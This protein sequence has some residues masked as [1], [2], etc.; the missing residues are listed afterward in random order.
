LDQVPIRVPGTLASQPKDVIGPLL[1]SRQEDGSEIRRRALFT[2]ILP[3]VP[4]Q[5]LARFVVS[6]LTADALLGLLSTTTL[7]KTGYVNV[8]QLQAETSLEE[9]AAKC[10]VSLDVHGDGK[11]V[12]LDCPFGCAGD[13]CGRREIAVNTDNPQKV[14]MCH[15]YQ[16]GFRG[17]LLTLMHGWL[18][19][20]RPADDKLRGDEFHRVKSIVASAVA[21]AVKAVND[22]PKTSTNYSPS[23]TPNRC[24]G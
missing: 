20:S 16:C 7:A 12:R 17:N 15:A 13:H 21:T 1:A 14:F 11:E 2:A 10:G 8:D 3:P 5:I 24:V 22:Q 19:G 4:E 6:Q 18:T 23:P 9:A